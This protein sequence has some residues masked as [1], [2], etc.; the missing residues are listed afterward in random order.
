M[1]P[2][3]LKKH[4]INALPGS[5]GEAVELTA[6]SAVVKECLSDHVYEQF[7]ENKRIEWDQFRIHVSQWE[8]DR[9]L[10]IL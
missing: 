4:K 2:Q 9:Y 3:E 1:T 10:S 7:I 6:N 5:L 8:M